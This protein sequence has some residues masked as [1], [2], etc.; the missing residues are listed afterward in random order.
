M[1]AAQQGK[2]R[3]PEKRDP[4]R[5][6]LASLYRAGVDP[7]TGEVKFGLP[8]MAFKMAGSGSK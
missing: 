7:A 3:Q 4:H 6:Y 2:K 1:L 8:S 5:E